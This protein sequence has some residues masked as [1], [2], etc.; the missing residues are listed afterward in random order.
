MTEALRL[1]I[2]HEVRAT[3]RR[4]P[5]VPADAR[6][7]IE[8]GIPVTVE[9][10]PQRVF[11]IA[12][13]AA[14]GCRIAEP[15]SWVDAPDEE[16]IV[17]LKEL[18]DAPA[19]LRHRHVFFGHAYKGQ[20]GGR[21]LLR[22]FTAGG[23]T[24]FDLEYLVDGRGH[25]LAA[26]GYWAGYAG[27]ALAVLHHQGRLSSPLQPAAKEALDAVLARSRR[28][29]APRALIVGAFGRCGRGAQA[30]LATAGITP[31]CW[32]LEETET[33]DRAALLA[34][35]ILINAVLVTEP[36]PPFL[37]SADLQ[38]PDRQLIVI[39]DVTCDVTSPCNMLP[40]NNRTTSWSAPT[41][42]LCD[43][44]PPLDIIAIDNLPALLPREASIA[45]SADLR[46]HLASLGSSEPWQRCRRTFHREL[47]RAG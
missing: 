34:H 19:A 13:Y 10:S 35:D 41:R 3:E 14:V 45:F 18:P 22:R 31:T 25:R 27:G 43:G 32:G 8:R 5:L 9:D 4:A 7:L 37:T 2:R 30:A 28:V 46:P 6:L 24:L 20:R 47:A 42:R 16:C 33:V 12:D 26:F 39:S 15:G 38:D 40:F 36:A 21:Q 11:P 1:W 17:G 23:G 29:V 44:P